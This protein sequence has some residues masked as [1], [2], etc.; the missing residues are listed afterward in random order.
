MTDQPF[1]QDSSA[2]DEWDAIARFVAGESTPEESAAIR[3]MLAADPARAALVGALGEALRS[4]N[5]SAPTA[6]EV[7]V[8]LAAV[9]GRR[10]DSRSASQPRRASIMSLDAYRARWRDA[11][12]KA[13]A[14]VLVVAGTG[15]LLRSVTGTNPADADSAAPAHFATPVGAI[16]SLRLPDGS[17][18]LL[19]PGSELTLAEGFGG[20]SREV[21]LEGD[22]R[23]D[24]VHDASR[25]F[26]VHTAAASFRDVGTIFSVH[27]DKADGARVVVTNGAVA[28]EAGATTAPVVLKAGDRA[29]IAR[30]GTVAVERAAASKEDMAWTD[31]RLVFRDASVQQVTSDLRRWY[32]IE[33][34]V[35]SAL[36][37]RKLTATFE[38]GSAS[39]VG[40]V[41]AAALGGG[42]KEDG[43]ILRII[44]SRA[45]TPSR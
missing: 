19:G 31:G 18:V 35:D 27:S 2:N 29:V 17:R 30:E 13:A 45:A 7:D 43:R 12:F 41:V 22:A 24:V 3:R 23:F 16:D 32:G 42:L 39:D 8:A 5:P 38:R 40:R 21:T 20:S 25:Q 36:A 44:P 28:V 34:R 37:S 26:V 9:L 10:A 11:R 6:S 1:P 14:A 33:L 15:M 4:P